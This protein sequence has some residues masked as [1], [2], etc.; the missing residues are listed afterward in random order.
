[1]AV[2]LIQ[3]GSDREYIGMRELYSATITDDIRRHN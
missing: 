1:M 2:W 3:V